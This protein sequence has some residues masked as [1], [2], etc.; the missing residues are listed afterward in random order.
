MAQRIGKKIMAA[1]DY[2]FARLD[3][4]TIN[5]KLSQGFVD[6]FS[7]ELKA[8]YTNANVATF[9]QKHNGFY[10]TSKFGTA[11]LFNVK[12]M[13]MRYY[14]SYT[15]TLNGVLDTVVTYQDYPANDE[16]RKVNRIT[17][18]QK[19]LISSNFAAKTQMNLVSSPANIYTRV[20]LPLAGI[21]QKMKQ[22]TGTKK[23]LINRAIFK[24]NIAEIDDE[25]LAVPLVSNLL[26]IKDE[27]VSEYFTSRKIPTDTISV[28]GTIAYEYDANNELRYFYKFD[29]SKI[30]TNE[31]ASTGTLPNQLSFQL[32]PVSIK[33][34][35]SGNTIEIKHQN[36]L[37]AVK[38][39]SAT[40][41]VNRRMKLQV[42]YSGF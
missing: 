31:F 32:I 7:S 9:H 33:K 11:S 1:R 3:S 35:G 18:P 24:V 8:N 2:G 41:D 42:V 39:C 6:G 22:L 12:S 27:R 28:L 40:D 25:T 15:Y 14:Y 4:N 37:S 36:L 5:I 17:L 29:L 19:A 21:K 38:L 13:F 34:D 26:M 16:I 23:L 30:L 10:I 20:S